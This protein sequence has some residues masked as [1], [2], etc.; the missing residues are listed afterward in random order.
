MANLDESTTIMLTVG[1]AGLRFDPPLSAGRVRQLIDSGELRA[2]RTARGVRL[3][4]ES[5]VRELAEKRRAARR[6]AS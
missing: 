6:S 2:I 5:A 1:E 4:A 3:V